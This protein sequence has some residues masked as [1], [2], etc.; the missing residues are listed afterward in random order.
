MKSG[1]ESTKFSALI[2]SILLWCLKIKLPASSSCGMLG[3]DSYRNKT[4]CTF[5]H[6]EEAWQILVLVGA[7][8][9]IIIG[10][11]K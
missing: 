3:G 1:C 5:K 6:C 9:Q 10:I 7:K 11:A 4:T 8:V 2:G